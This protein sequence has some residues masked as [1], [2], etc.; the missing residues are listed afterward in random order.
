MN[1]LK[2]EKQ[3][4]VL[5]LLVEG[6]SIRSIER[7]T[8][9]HRDTI[10]RLMIRSGNKCQELLNESMQGLN[11]RY[12]ECDE[13]WTYVAKKQARL[14]KEEK[15]NGSECG[16]QYV[17][18][19]LDSETRLVPHFFVG[20]RTTFNAYWFMQQLKRRVNGNFQLTTDA[21]KGYLEAVSAAFGRNIHYAM[22][23]KVYHGDGNGRREGYSPS[24]LK[25]VN[26]GVISGKPE[27]KKI[28]TSY[29]ERQNLTIRTQLRR[30]T[31]LTNAFS[32]KLDSLKA[33]LALH[34]W[35]YNFMRYHKSL[36]MT[37]A[38]AAGIATT[39]GD[40]SEILN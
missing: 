6:N 21:F 39:F 18:V 30:F 8:G 40:W 38:M 2:P 36:R 13:I 17:F 16:D 23:Q 31:R 34:F 35:H 28:C 5:T 25:K 26:I 20:K 12:M 7:I 9:V 29:V 14:T 10:I 37:P 22:L 19:A 3:E 32:K 1:R 4:M 11:C 27:K 33:A 15:R 24:Q